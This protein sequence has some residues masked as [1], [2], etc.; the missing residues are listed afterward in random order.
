MKKIAVTLVVLLTMSCTIT[1]NAS[2]EFKEENK[3]SLISFLDAK[4][5]V[6]EQ[7]DVAVLKDFRTFIAYNDSEKLVAPE[8]YFFNKDG[9][10]VINNFK[11]TRC[12]LVI[13][14]IREVNNAPLD[15]SKDHINNWLKNFTF[16][17]DSSH[18]TNPEDDYDV[19][20]IISWAKFA[21]PIAKGNI[22]DTTLS[23][24][25]SLKENPDLKIKTIL[26][27]IDVQESWALSDEYKE[28][29][30]MKNTQGK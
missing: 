15:E 16:L 8:A 24:Y 4:E 25:K 6:Y 2:I 23:W 21:D 9:Y 18:H 28:A 1:R 17:S 27:N 30:G 14:N 5:A 26:L 29:I 7:E 10:R 11:G 12:G 19:Y 20:V 3:A 22:N 13:N